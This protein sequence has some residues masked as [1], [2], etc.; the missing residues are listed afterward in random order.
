MPPKAKG[1]KKKGG[2]QM[3]EKFAEGHVLKDIY[4]TNWTLGKPIGQGG[5]GLIYLAYKGE[6]KGTAEYVVKIE[7]KDNGP[8]FCE[9]HFYINCAKEDEIKN[10]VKSTG[11]KHL[12]IPKYISSGLCTYN[13][14]EYRFLVMDRFLKDLQTVINETPS[15]QLNESGVLCLMR[16]VMHSL[17]YIH[18]KGYAHGDIKGA[19]LMLKSDHESFLVD[20]GL[21]QRFKRDNVH[22]KYEIKPER[23][24]N[25]T[26]EYTS[27][28]A[29][30]GALCN[31]RSDLEILGY[32]VVH[33][34]SG[35]LP[36]ISLIANCEQVQQSKIKNMTNVKDFIKATLGSVNNISEPVKSFIEFYLG[37]VNKL[38]HDH[39][40]PYAKIHAKI[41]DALKALGHG[42]ASADHFHLFTP[43]AKK[44]AKATA[45]AAAV[46]TNG[47]GSEVEAVE[48]KGR[49]GGRKRQAKAAKAI[50]SEDE[51]SEA[52]R[53]KPK[54]K[55]TPAARRNG[56]VKA[57][58]EVVVAGSDQ[59]EA[60]TEKPTPI[61]RKPGR[62]KTNGTPSTGKRTARK[63]AINYQEESEE[64]EITQPKSPKPKTATPVA[65]SSQ[66]KR[67]NGK[68]VIPDSDSEQDVPE[69]RARSPTPKRAV[70][71][72]A[73][74]NGKQQHAA[75]HLLETPPTSKYPLRL[76]PTRQMTPTS[77]SDTQT[78]HEPEP[79][80]MNVAQREVLDMKTKQV[81][82]SVLNGGERKMNAAQLDI[83]NKL[84][85]GSSVFSQNH[86]QSPA[87]VK[88]SPL[89]L[90]NLEK[91][92]SVVLVKKRKNVPKTTVHTQTDK[93]YIADVRKVNGQIW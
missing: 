22:Q 33:W 14:K 56:A 34:L 53:E 69:V 7:P 79:A 70:K 59:E 76:T 6:A 2:Y 42:S 72:K 20:F 32:C 68:L 57:A 93:S 55:R 17:E 54:P 21:A 78:A 3:P 29:H 74:E 26:I 75:R 16:Q 24:H 5:F 81:N 92:G 28:D 63:E 84:K 85:T 39:E 46:E 36:W 31:R 62:S 10:Y 1:A 48:E 65:K 11:L 58:A 77:N 25:G 9:T 19:N 12:A 88:S 13:E 35:T 82:S 4:K 15:H 49:G 66:V 27:R 73:D 47:T 80:P 40:P 50:P 38:E 60:E 41:T 67:T 71:A 8:L 87:G 83:I 86:N 43:G 89:A 44:S 18:K 30:A 23:R 64:E 90:G 91:K 37:E 52:E 51:D 45:A 61:A